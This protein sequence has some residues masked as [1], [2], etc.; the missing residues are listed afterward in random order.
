MTVPSYSILSYAFWLSIWIPVDWIIP[1]YHTWVIFALA[2]YQRIF[3]VADGV[4]ADPDDFWFWQFIIALLGILVGVVVQWVTMAPKLLS[5][6][7]GWEKVVFIKFPVLTI[8]YIASQIIFWRLPVPDSPWGIVLSI[9]ITSVIIGITWAWSYDQPWREG[10]PVNTYVFWLWVLAVNFILQVFHFLL[11][12]SLEA[13]YVSIIAG[14]ATALIIII[15]QL[16][17]TGWWNK[18][19]R[20]TTP[21]WRTFS[22]GSASQHHYYQHDSREQT[23]VLLQKNTDEN[24]YE[25]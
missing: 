2:L 5:T 14:A 7:H 1:V 21:F 11:Y 20:M 8:A 12:T 4:I 25:E 18:D 22:S 23:T 9:L 6:R 15:S 24:R 3:L 19:G 17:L 10:D 13:K 16:L